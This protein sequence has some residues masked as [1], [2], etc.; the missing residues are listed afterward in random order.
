MDTPQPPPPQSFTEITQSAEST[1]MTALIDSLVQC[2]S[3]SQRSQANTTQHPINQS[4][5]NMFTNHRP[6]THH[7]SPTW[8]DRPTWRDPPGTTDPPGVTTHT[9]RPA[10]LARPTFLLRPTHQ[11]Q[12]IHPSQVSRPSLATPKF[13]L[14]RTHRDSKYLG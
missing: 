12:L 7:H 13:F 1:D 6:S 4:P 2:T 5:H 11:A 8:H 9:A 3:S 14:S 10:H